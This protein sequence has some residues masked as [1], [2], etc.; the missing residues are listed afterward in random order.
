MKALEFDMKNSNKISSRFDELTNKEKSIENR[1]S[2]QSNLEVS[3]KIN[4]LE[5]IL[6]S[7]ITNTLNK[8]LNVLLCEVTNLSKTFVTS[9]T[10]LRKWGRTTPDLCAVLTIQILASLIANCL[11]QS[12]KQKFIPN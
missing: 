1:G 5:T 2:S 7:A 8:H 3:S 11:V 9:T 12:C 10:K 4:E 6:S